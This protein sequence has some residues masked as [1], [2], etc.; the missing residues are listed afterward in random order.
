MVGW[1][2]LK[3]LT[4]VRVH[5]RQLMDKVS[6]DSPEFLDPIYKTLDEGKPI[7]IEFALANH[8]GLRNQYLVQNREEFEK[9]K[10]ETFYAFRPRALVTVCFNPVIVWDGPITFEASRLMWDD[11]RAEFEYCDKNRKCL[12]FLEYQQLLENKD[13]DVIIIK[14]VEWWMEDFCAY[15]P[16]NDGT[17]KPGAY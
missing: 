4:V 7:A 12:D 11:P 6:T 5:P 10:Q 16:M 8:G 9:L 13:K 2:S 14:R 17:I 15:V 1:K 3:L